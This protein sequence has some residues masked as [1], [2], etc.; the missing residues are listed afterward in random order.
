MTTNIINSRAVNYSL[1]LKCVSL[2]TGPYVECAR[3]FKA[4]FSKDVEATRPNLGQ[5]VL[6]ILTGLLLTIPLLNL[7]TYLVLYAIK[8]CLN[9]K[10]NP[11][12]DVTKPEITIPELETSPV[13]IDWMQRITQAIKDTDF[14]LFVALVNTGK[15]L[16]CL[17]KQFPELNA[18]TLFWRLAKNDRSTKPYMDYFLDHAQVDFNEQGMLGNTALIWAI[19]NANNGTALS[20]LEHAGKGSYLNIRGG[21]GNTALHLLIAKG[22]ENISREGQFL[23][24]SNLTLIK[25]I[26]ELGCEVNI[27]NAMGNTPLH[28]ACLRRD[29][30]MIAL[31]LKAKAKKDVLNR[32]GLSPKELLNVGYQTAYRK[33][34]QTCYYFLLDEIQYRASWDQVN[35][36]L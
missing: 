28:L 12:Q 19:A 1:N 24:C 34:E 30:E 25:K 11:Q 9:R 27:A 16:D 21:S 26:I 17:N 31:L 6:H 36:L 4:A 3:H 32:D 5:R 10:T 29:P 23:E 8:S 13:A 18:S 15:V 7:I 22:Y 33:L 35:A 2:L 14:D 20:I